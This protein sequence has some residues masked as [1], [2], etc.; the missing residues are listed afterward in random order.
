MKNCLREPLAIIFQAAETLRSAVDAHNSGDQETAARLFGETNL[1]EIRDWTESLWGAANNKYVG[2]R[3]EL[4]KHGVLSKPERVAKRMPNLAEQKRILKRDGFHCR[5]CGIPVIHE[6]IRKK[7]HRS[8]PGSV[9]WG[10]TNL[11]QHAAFQAMWLQFDHLLPHSAGGT[12]S[13]NNI[14][15]T[16]APCNYGKSDYTIE[17]LGLTDP[18][19]RGAFKS[20]WNGLEDFK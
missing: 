2:H 6:R 16:C 19:C 5:F 10:R 18:F 17:E 12:N 9:P 7:I 3:R 4:R 11:S 20:D 14:L 8:Y 15:I 13:L 1:C